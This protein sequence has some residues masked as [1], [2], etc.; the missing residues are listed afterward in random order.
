LPHHE[1]NTETEI[2]VGLVVFLV[3]VHLAAICFW[4]WLLYSPSWSS[5]NSRGEEGGRSSE[6]QWRTPRE[7]IAQ[8]TRANE[9][10]RL[11]KV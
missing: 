1:L 11:G 5:S 7:I 10:A 2:E 6:Q 9:K 8:Y 4:L 3:A